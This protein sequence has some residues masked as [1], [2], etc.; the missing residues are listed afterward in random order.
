MG[1]ADI[2]QISSHPDVEIVAI[3]DVDTA[4]MAAAAPRLENSPMP[5]G[6]RTGA[7]CWIRKAIE[8][9]R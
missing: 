7:N 5:A 3:C 1:W 9:I 8:S 4:R 6:I 2:Q